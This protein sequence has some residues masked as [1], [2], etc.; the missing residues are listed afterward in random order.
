[1]HQKHLKRV[2]YFSRYKVRPPVNR[3]RNNEQNKEILNPIGMTGQYRPYGKRYSLDFEGVS[4]TELKTILCY[5]PKF[6]HTRRFGHVRT[7]G[8]EN[9]IFEKISLTAVAQIVHKLYRLYT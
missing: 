8:F 4:M 6:G 9:I 7:N 2:V 3:K 5:V 1:M